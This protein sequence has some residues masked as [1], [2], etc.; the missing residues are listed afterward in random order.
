MCLVSVTYWD[1]SFTRG[2]GFRLR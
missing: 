1:C 2:T